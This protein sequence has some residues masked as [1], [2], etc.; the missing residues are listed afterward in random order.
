MGR[1]FTETNSS[2]TTRVVNPTQEL[3]LNYLQSPLP[4]RPKLMPDELFSSWVLRI[5]QSM[6]MKPQ[7]FCQM[8]WPGKAFWNRSVD[9]SAST[10]LI[11]SLGI[12]TGTPSST[13]ES[14]LL[15]SLEGVLFPKMVRNGNTRW[16]LPLAIYH[17]TNLRSG[18]SFCPLCM[19]EG[20]P[21]FRKAWRLSLFTSCQL[22]QCELLD[23][24]HHCKYP[25]QPHRVE[26]GNRSAYST[27]PLYFC[28]NCDADLRV[29]QL[30]PVN[31][32]LAL[33]EANFMNAL[34]MPS[35]GTLDRFSLLSHVLLLLTSQRPRMQTFRRTVADE[36]R[37]TLIARWKRD[38]SS[39]I[40]FDGMSVSDRR[41]FLGA[42]CWLLEDWPGKFVDIARRSNL[43][44]S[45]LTRDFENAPG[46][47]LQAVHNVISH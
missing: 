32:S 28:S 12:V 45:D 17:R 25:M 7:S 19:R 30:K 3:W 41:S 22:H 20:E 14:S 47:Y 1:T 35:P 46:W 9:R 5:A 40:Y 2:L 6:G 15:S 36:N 39:T 10:E 44:N 11:R 37:C 26:M 13:V 42:A 24:C 27:R 29:A 34:E 23:R 8:M 38:E 33:H 4:L 31:K 18:L 21:Y 43:R 16:I